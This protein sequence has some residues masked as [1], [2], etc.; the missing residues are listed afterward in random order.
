MFF[1]IRK[2]PSQL[3]KQKMGHKY[4]MYLCPKFIVEGD[5]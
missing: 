1:Q 5:N 4:R 3:I 2:T